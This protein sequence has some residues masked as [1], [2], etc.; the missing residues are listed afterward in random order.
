MKG[1]FLAL[2]SPRNELVPQKSDVAHA[3][4][5]N[6]ELMALEVRAAGIKVKKCEPVATITRRYFPTRLRFI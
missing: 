4:S 6:D 3:R 2:E 1:R 5:D